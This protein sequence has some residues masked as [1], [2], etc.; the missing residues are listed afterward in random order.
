MIRLLWSA[1]LDSTFR[2]CQLSFQNVEVQPI[3]IIDKER[4]AYEYEM[5]AH[6]DILDYLRKRNIR[7]SIH[8]V[9]YVPLSSVTINPSIRDAF[10]R[11]YTEHPIGAQYIWLGSYT[12]KVGYCELGEEGF[13]KAPGVL[14]KMFQSKGVFKND[15]YGNLIIDR[16]KSHPDVSLVFGHYYFPIYRINTYQML[17][18]LKEWNMNEILS[19]IR[20]CAS[21]K[22]YNC[23]I[24]KSCRSRIKIGKAD[25]FNF[26][27]DAVLYYEIYL[28]L[29]RIDKSEKFLQAFRSYMLD[30]KKAGLIYYSRSDKDV[31]YFFQKLEKLLKMSRKNVRKILPKLKSMD[32]FY[33]YVN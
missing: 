5:K 19:L 18:Y 21:D 23:G 11:L 31:L 28:A 25:V 30:N 2:L 13:V 16:E 33:K 15:E 22:P 14:G 17:D 4:P 27:P 20:F 10:M 1:G 9:L 26:S 12:E 32:D 3:Y 8:D 29:Q 6:S 7:A 24:C